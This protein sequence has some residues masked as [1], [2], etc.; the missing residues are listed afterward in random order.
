MSRSLPSFIALAVSSLLATACAGSGLS[1][2]DEVSPGVAFLGGREVNFRVDRDHLVIGPR[3]GRFSAIRIE[4]P[5]ASLELYDIRVVFGDGSSFSPETRLQFHAGEGT[6]RID[7]P[8]GNRV[9]REITFLYRSDRPAQ[10][11]AHVRVYGIR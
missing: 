5:D 7:L 3:A 6:R 9:I 2:G 4:V 1:P 10:G 8:G 11:R